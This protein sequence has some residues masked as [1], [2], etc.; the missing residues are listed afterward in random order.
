[1]IVV[2]STAVDRALLDAGIIAGSHL[3]SINGKDVCDILDYEFLSSDAELEL[4][5]GLPSGD[6]VTLEISRDDL[7]GLD[8]EFEPDKPER[9][10]NNCV[11]CFV[12]QLPKG[13]RRT[14]YIKDEDYRLSFRY[15][16]YV[17]LTNL[18]EDDFERI[19]E[20]RLSPLYVSVHTTDETLRR[21]M[22]GREDIPDLMPQLG[23]LAE[24]GIAL[25]TQVVLCPGW[26][27][28]T[29]LRRTVADLAVMYPAVQSV[30]VVPVGLTR[31]RSRL[32]QME[33][34]T[35]RIAS[36]AVADLLDMH[37]EFSEKLGCGFVYPADEFFISAGVEIPPSAFYGDFPQF[38]NGVGMVRQLLDG[39]DAKGIR[40]PG[41]LRV[42]VATGRLIADTLSDVLGQKWSAYPKVEYDIL[43]VENKLLGSSITVS[44]L[45]CGKDIMDALRKEREIGDCIVVPPNCLNDDG[46]FLDDLTMADI[47]REFGRPVTQADYSAKETLRRI[48][49]EMYS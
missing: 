42:C 10:G 7:V 8:L 1:M 26:N 45:L 43:P 21:K 28:G 14:L 49:T 13:L 16:N 25:H 27:D 3:V 19:V 40:L 20:Q 9:C 32:P 41:R 6:K 23:K 35:Q 33:P 11:F 29:R 48:A 30:A 18:S 38:E 31:H 34:V 46:L 22:L 44:G 5:F 37:R 24:G 4:V 2:K 15:G 47:S 39:E 36:A 12:H 17:T